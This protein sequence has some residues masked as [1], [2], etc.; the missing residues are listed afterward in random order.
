MDV[1][2]PDEYRIDVARAKRSLEALALAEPDAPMVLT[3]AQL[4]AGGLE[5]E[6]EVR[7][8]AEEASA[9]VATVDSEQRLAAAG[10][11][12]YLLRISRADPRD[13]PLRKEA[14]EW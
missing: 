12:L 5:G 6:G 2:L 8:R 10:Q 9:L 3:I 14:D 1:E 4:G 13:R 11:S 7:L